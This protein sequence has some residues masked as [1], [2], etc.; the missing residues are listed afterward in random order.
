MRDTRV[1][2]LSF[3]LSWAVNSEDRHLAGFAMAVC[4]A[5]SRCSVIL[6]RCFL[7]PGTECGSLWAPQEDPAC[8]HS[9]EETGCLGRESPV[10]AS[11]LRALPS[12][13]L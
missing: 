7:C 4:L 11:P 13:A 8:G 6:N 5:Q 1:R 9:P 10:L 2:I 12:M 3:V